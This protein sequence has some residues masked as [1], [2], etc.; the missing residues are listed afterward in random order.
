MTD[1]KDLPPCF[2]TFTYS[3]NAKLDWAIMFVVLNIFTAGIYYYF[4][5]RN[6]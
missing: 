4:I 3:K 2:L 1:R 5:Y 6:K